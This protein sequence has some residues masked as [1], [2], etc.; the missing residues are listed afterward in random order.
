M[1]W[2]PIML[3]QLLNLAFF[4]LLYTYYSIPNKRVG[5]CYEAKDLVDQ[6]NQ[7]ACVWSQYGN[8]IANL[9][10]VIPEHFF[11]LTNSFNIAGTL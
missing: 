2:Q 7:Y 6:I 9:R 10:F 5:D 4:C 11:G 8:E 1:T 3:H